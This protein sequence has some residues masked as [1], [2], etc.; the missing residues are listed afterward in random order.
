MKKILSILIV[1][2]ML[3]TSPLAVMANTAKKTASPTVKTAKVQ[4]VKTKKAKTTTKTKVK[5]VIKNNKK[6]TTQVKT[7]KATKTNK[8]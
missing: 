6:T 7:K 5:K 8:K 4:V 1:F 3:L 2:G